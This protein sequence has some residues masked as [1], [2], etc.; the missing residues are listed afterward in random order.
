MRKICAALLLCLAASVFGDTPTTCAPN[1]AY[2]GF[3]QPSQWRYIAAQ[4][5]VGQQSPIAIGLPVISQRN[6]PITVRYHD[7]ALTVTLRNSGHDFRIVPPPPTQT[8]KYEIDVPGIGTATLD[9]IHFHTPAEHSIPQHGLL[10]GEIHFVHKAGNTTV[11]IAV[12]LRN[13]GTTPNT[14]LQPITSRLP[15][16]L[17]DFR[18]PTVN[19]AR[20]LPQSITA[21]YRYTGSLTTPACDP[22]VIFLVVPTP[23]PASTTEL[24]KLGTFGRNARPPQTRIMNPLTTITHVTL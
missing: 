23:M 8:I 11:V 21:Y 14:A 2:E 13:N 24:G 17:C 22:G 5:A 9:N 20:L 4:C 15:I 16:D 19:L 7:Q 18:T 1:Y 12:V 10:N 3:T 6:A